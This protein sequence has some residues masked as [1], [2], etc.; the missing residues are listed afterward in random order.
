MTT[1]AHVH[2]SDD[3]F[4]SG[5]TNGRSLRSIAGDPWDNP[6]LAPGSMTHRLFS[7]VGSAVYAA[8]GV[9]ILGTVQPA[10]GQAL[11]QHEPLL[12]GTRTRS[13]DTAF[14]RMRQSYEI[15]FG[16]LLGATAEDRITAAYT[17]RELH[18]V[19]Q[20]RM[21]GGSRYH[22]WQ[23]DVWAF[24]WLGIFMGVVEAYEFARGYASDDE[25]FEAIA[26]CIE[27]GKLFGVQGIPETRPEFEAYWDNFIDN[28]AVT[29]QA[30]QYIMEQIGP[31]IVKPAQAQWI[32]QPLW[33]AITLPLRRLFRVGV[34]ATFPPVI[35][36]EVG[37]R[38]TRFDRVEAAMH[39]RFWRM[40]PRRATEYAGQAGF[41]ALTTIGEPAWKTDFSEK[42]LAQRRASLGARP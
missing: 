5:Q 20:G 35:K 14:V 13:I 15:A 9:F 23:R 29:N 7:D 39:R 38:E 32:P 42:R 30:V 21:P 37:F 3:L 25:R 18:R 28:E 36:A 34:V 16:I 33:A 11:D 19:I 31:G 17:L 24:A 1:D 10:V 2:D 26:G 6:L 4:G 12:N 8:M 27:V 22:A 41:R 40:V